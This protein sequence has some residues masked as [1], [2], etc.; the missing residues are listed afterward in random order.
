[1][2]VGDTGIFGTVGINT[3]SPTQRLHLK[4]GNMLLE[5]T[6]G[7]VRLYFYSPLR[8]Y[9][10][11]TSGSDGAFG[12]Y[13]IDASQ[14]RLTVATSGNV[15][16]GTDSPTQELQVHGSFPQEKL[17]NTLNSNWFTLGTGSVGFSF[18][19][20][21]GNEP[22]IIYYGTPSDTMNLLASGA[23]IIGGDTGPTGRLEVRGDIG[24]HELCLYESETTGYPASSMQ[25]DTSSA[26]DWEVGASVG[27]DTFFIYDDSAGW[28]YVI[29]NPNT[30]Q[31]T[32]WGDVVVNGDLYADGYYYNASGSPQEIRSS[33]LEGP[34]VTTSTRGSGTLVDGEAVIVLPD[35]FAKATSETGLTVTLTPTG[36][37][38]ELYVV[39]KTADRIVVQEA[40]GRTG[41]FD[42]LV[43]G[44]RSGDSSQTAAA[45]PTSTGISAARWTQ[46]PG[47][48]SPSPLAP[49]PEQE[50]PAQ[51]VGEGRNWLGSQ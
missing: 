2:G 50:K 40:S 27:Y 15:G 29:I 26:T 3:A 25:F 34:Q 51:R 41:T 30:G 22:F 44:T 20:N 17:T 10:F 7:T 33:S 1:M 46:R 35:A 45:S 32:L 19:D 12:I 42:Y 21:A 13:D 47:D 14:R 18:D 11:F 37:W 38:L 5:S 43:Q 9:M 28:N 24:G 31:I 39:E 4:D 16:I 49:E 8:K 36:T 48:P 23:V 6:S